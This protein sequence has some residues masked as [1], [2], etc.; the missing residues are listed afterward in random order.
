V[1]TAV[2]R[3]LLEERGPRLVVDK[4]VGIERSDLRQDGVVGPSEDQTQTRICGERRGAVK[5]DEADIQAF[6]QA[7]EE[8]GKRA[9]RESRGRTTIRGSG[10]SGILPSRSTLAGGSPDRPTSDRDDR[11]SPDGTPSAHRSART[12][13]SGRRLL[14]LCP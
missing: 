4:A 10:D 2:A 7:L 3:E 11:V 1:D 8:P 13:I 6:V 14:P 12:D 5:L 9:A